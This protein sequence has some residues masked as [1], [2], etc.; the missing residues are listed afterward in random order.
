MVQHVQGRILSRT[1]ISI[2]MHTMWID[3]LAGAKYVMM[4]PI[5]L[6]DIYYIETVYFSLGWVTGLLMTGVIN[7]ILRY[8]AAKKNIRGEA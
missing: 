3:I 1:L 5:V 7:R 8:Y 6:V 4:L 2:S